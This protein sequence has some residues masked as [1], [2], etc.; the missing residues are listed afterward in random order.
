[1]SKTRAQSACALVGLLA[2]GI[3]TG[4][5]AQVAFQHMRGEGRDIRMT[6]I[7]DGVYQFMTM[8]DSYVRQLNSVVVVTDRDVLVFDTNTRPSSAALILAEIRKITNKPVRYL[9][10]SHGHPDHWSGNAVYADAYPYV[11]IIATGLT[12]DHMR[13]MSGVWVPRF[14]KELENRRVALA[15]EESSGKQADGS[16]LT[17]EQLQQDKTDVEDYATFTDETVKLRR[18]Y[19]TITYADSL[20]I[21]HGGREFRFLSVTGDA[22]G[23]TVLYLPK[24]KILVTGDAVSFP[25]P[26]VSDNPAAELASLRMLTALDA[27]TI[28]PGHG[29]AFHDHA[30]INLELRFFETVFG[31]MAKARANGVT[32]VDDMQN[33]VTGDAVRESLA[34]GDPDLEARFRSRVKDFVTAAMAE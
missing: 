30:F 16:P 8:R 1:M 13:R 22:L 32:A 9:V 25:I 2:V 10:N 14:T 18:V 4:G 27:N 24:E 34:H 6:V 11:D 29:P 20:T 26:Y 15:A 17:P 23:T 33:V 12:R 7:A 5:R 31:E 19:P 3:P 21:V 28:I